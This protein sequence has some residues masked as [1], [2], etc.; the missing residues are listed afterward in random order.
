MVSLSMDT[1]EHEVDDLLADGVV[2]E[3][4]VEHLGEG[5]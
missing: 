3:G 2:A 5:S 4:V 1:V